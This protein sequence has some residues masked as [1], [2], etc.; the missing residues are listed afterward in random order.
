[1]ELTGKAAKTFINIVAACKPTHFQPQDEALLVEYAR[2]VAL[3]DEAAGELRINGA[4][5]IG[6]RGPQVSPWIVVQEK[7]LKAMATLALRLRISPQAR[8]QIVAGRPQRP[9][10]YYEQQALLEG[11]DG[12][13]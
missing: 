12:S 7:A 10:S 11:Q 1:V 6:S 13:A 2:A 3:A 4:V 5:V 9:L 8:S